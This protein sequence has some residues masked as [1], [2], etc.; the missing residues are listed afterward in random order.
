MNLDTNNKIYLYLASIFFGTMFTIVFPLVGSL[1]TE[2]L[3][4]MLRGPLWVIALTASLLGGLL[5]ASGSWKLADYKDLFLISWVSI[6]LGVVEFMVVAA[7]FTSDW[8]L[9]GW[10]K[11][12][13]IIITIGM[14]AA[15]ALAVIAGMAS[16]TTDPPDHK[17]PNNE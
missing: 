16:M 6:S 7:Y 2:T 15:G 12:P 9:P 1:S 4:P 17:T 10:A 8:T 11:G 3:P 5:I 13:S 14:A